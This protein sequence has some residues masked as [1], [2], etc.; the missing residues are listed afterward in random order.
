REANGLIAAF[1]NGKPIPDPTFRRRAGHEVEAII[2]QSDNRRLALDPPPAVQDLSKGRAAS[3]ARRAIGAHPVEEG[4]RIG[5]GYLELRKRRQV[6]DADA[7]AHG[8][9]LSANELEIDTPAIAQHILGGDAAAGI[10]PR[11]LPAACLFV[12]GAE[13]ARVVMGAGALDMSAGPALLCR[14]RQSDARRIILNRPPTRII[15]IGPCP[16]APWIE[17]ARRDICAALD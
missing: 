16:E 15:G 1:V 12:D 2:A 6:A 4:F 7:F 11:P 5:A 8:T 17:G 14:E 9:T 10:P 13:P 3:A